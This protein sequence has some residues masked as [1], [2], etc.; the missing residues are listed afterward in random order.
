MWLPQESIAVCCRHTTSIYVTSIRKYC[1]LLQ[2][3]HIYICD[4]HKKV[5]LFVAGTPHRSVTSIRRYWHTTSISVTSIRMYCCLLQAHHIYICDFHKKVLL[6][7]AGTPHLYMWLPQESIAVCCRHTTSISVTST[8]KCCC[9]LQAHHVYICDFHKKVLAHHI[10][11]CDFHKKVLLFVAG[12]PHLYLWLPQES[13]AVCC[14]HTTSISVTSTRK[15]CCLLQAHH[16]YI[17]DFHK[18]VLLFVAGTPH[19]YLWLP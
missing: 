19:L 13:I 18:K 4:F 11:I 7:V 14:R 12:T 9:L 15:Y 8:R 2:A 1:C 10:Y 3:H 16:I 6:F 17:C 5:L